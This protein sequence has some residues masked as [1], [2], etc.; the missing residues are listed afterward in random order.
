[1]DIIDFNRDE[2]IVLAEI[3]HDIAPVE[4]VIYQEHIVSRCHPLE[5]SSDFQNKFIFI[6]CLLHHQQPSSRDSI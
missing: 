4:S 1:M 5:Y 6:S 2:V 3:L